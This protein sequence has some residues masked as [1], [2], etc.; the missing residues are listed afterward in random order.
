MK[1]KE[2]PEKPVKEAKRKT[3]AVAKDEVKAAKPSTAP[4]K[5]KKETK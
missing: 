1:G 5:G 2:I 3:K 4:A